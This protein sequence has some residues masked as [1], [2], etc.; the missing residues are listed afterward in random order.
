MLNKLCIYLEIFIY[1]LFTTYQAFPLNLRKIHFIQ[2][3]IFILINWTVD[4]FLLLK[5]KKYKLCNKGKHKYYVI[6]LPSTLKS[7]HFIAKPTKL[8]HRR[9][10]SLKILLAALVSIRTFIFAESSGFRDNL[11]ERYHF[12]AS[13]LWFVFFMFR[14][15][16][17]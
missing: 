16:F 9:D 10:M 15:S 2:I 6:F 17:A 11:C 8:Y 1:S 7:Q 12:H 13:F 3:R 14:F 5:L 4:L